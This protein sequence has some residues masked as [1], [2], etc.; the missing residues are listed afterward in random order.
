LRRAWY[1]AIAP[2]VRQLP[3]PVW[4]EA[5][6]PGLALAPRCNVSG[7]YPGVQ[8]TRMQTKVLDL[9]AQRLPNKEIAER[10]NIS[11]YTLASHKKMLYAKFGVHDQVTL[12][13]IAIEYFGDK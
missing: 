10:L 8:L 5:S 7:N 1:D 6:D 11:P 3:D 2:L 4:S 9:V 12:Y 13:I